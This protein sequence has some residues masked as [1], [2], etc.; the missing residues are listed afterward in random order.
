[1]I[2]VTKFIIDKQTLKDL[3]VFSEN[4]GS[5]SVYNVF[6]QT[7]TIAGRTRLFDI[8]Q[9]PFNNINDIMLRRDSIMFFLNYR[10]SLDVKNEEI[11]LIEFYLDSKF[12]MYKANVLDVFS[13]Y[14][15]RNSS[16]NYYV[17]K[18]G[19][20]YLIKITRYLRNF[21]LEQG[22]NIPPAYLTQI[23][24]EILLT[25]EQGVLSSAM[26][27]DEEKL[28]FV[29]VVKLD[30]SIRGREK[31]NI[32]RVLQLIYELDIFENTAIV[33]NS[34]GMCFP[35]FEEEGAIKL[36]IVGIFHPAIERPTKN[37]ICL[38]AGQNIMF[39]TGSNMAGKSSLLKSIGLNI[40]LAHLGFPVAADK[41]NLSVFNGLFT[42]I[43]LSD[44]INQ[45]LSHYYSE[46]KRVKEVA[47]LL[48]KQKNIF[49]IFDELFKGTNVK[50]A[51]DGSSLILSELAGIK[52]SAFIVS[53]H[54][55]EL[56]KPLAKF[57]NISFR[58]L[59]TYFDNGKPVF[60]H[61]LK[62]GVSDETVGMYILQNEGIIE[63]L[64][65][66]S[67]K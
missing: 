35:T 18:T 23:F 13:D 34:K 44:N 1:M 25:I 29:D 42:T 27:L 30:R 15:S 37:D 32:K 45:G 33:A 67:K 50:D 16:N 62:N 38:D 22:K 2:D 53:T 9:N 66:A 36:H 54:I 56:A 3:N 10:L 19:L 59:E 60:T 31:E 17:I 24:G 52:D 12:K 43:N 48:V 8:M 55:V 20:K 6:K 7:R 64:K 28:R 57:S 47:E 65:M 63:I 58:Y 26:L 39:L 49:V 21:I 51:F 14:I 46:V 41:M 5:N 11:D 4:G 61:L 40:Y